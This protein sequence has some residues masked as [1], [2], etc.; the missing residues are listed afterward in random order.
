MDVVPELGEVRLLVRRNLYSR[1]YDT[2]FSIWQSQCILTSKVRCYQ[3]IPLTSE[4]QQ[5]ERGFS[6]PH[7]R[8][9]KMISTT[10]SYIG[11]I[12][13]YF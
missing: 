2:T 8:H 10:K 5:C 1:L 9:Y 4:A 11:Q 7:S 12:T 3:N 13:Y 6:E